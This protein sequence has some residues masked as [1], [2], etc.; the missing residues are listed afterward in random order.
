MDCRNQYELINL[1]FAC[2]C[3]PFK[4]N[5]RSTTTC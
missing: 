2:H 5:W 1:L 3:P 4:S